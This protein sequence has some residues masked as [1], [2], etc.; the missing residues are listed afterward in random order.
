VS[1]LSRF[2]YL[3]RTIAAYCL[4]GRSQLTFWHETPEINPGFVPGQLGEYY[5]TFA[6]K[7]DYGGPFDAQG[8]PQLDYRGKLGRQYNPIAIAQYGLGN[9]TL[10]KRSGDAER[11]RKFLLVADWLE[12]HLEK[13]PAGLSVWNHHFDWE[14]RS[15]L[16]APWYSGLAQGQGIS[17]LLRAHRETS[18][19][20]YLE[21]ARRAFEPFAR[22][23]E[24]GGVV[25]RDE[26]ARPWLE[27]YIV[28][29]PT[30]ILNGFIWA[31]WGVYDY[32]LATG[33]GAA[34]KLWDDSVGTLREALDSYDAGFWSLYEHSGTAMRMIASR[35]YH[36]LHIVQLRILHRLTGEKA[37]E[38]TADRWDR[39]R[40][41]WWKRTRAGVHKAVFK[42]CYY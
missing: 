11:R 42:L 9:Y 24:E 8:I 34:K 20:R 27:E 22:R 30:H 17:M 41:S 5:M 26:R 35:F 25:Y 31:S 4:P 10:Y 12:S 29:P 6:A 14:Y 7:A 39:Y 2:H 33:D 40:A 16:K 19:G 36:S 18:E 37:F 38:E 21:A 32:H 1:V 15:P 3:R 23:V 13:N 28:S